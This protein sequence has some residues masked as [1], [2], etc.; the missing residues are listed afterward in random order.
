MYWRLLTSRLTSTSNSDQLNFNRRP[1]MSDITVVESGTMAQVSIVFTFQIPNR[2]AATDLP[3]AWIWCFLNLN[4][5][6]R[7]FLRKVYRRCLHTSDA[8]ASA[9]VSS[10]SFS[11]VLRCGLDKGRVLYGNWECRSTRQLLVRAPLVPSVRRCFWR[12]APSSAAMVP[13]CPILSLSPHR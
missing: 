12:L 11:N 7:Y 3:F 1:S 6:A 13:A 4:S 10:L 9:S 2:I 8:L 5:A